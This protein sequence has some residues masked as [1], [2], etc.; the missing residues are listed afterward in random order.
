MNPRKNPVLLVPVIVVA[1]ALH[2][3]RLRTANGG[4]DV[5]TVS[6]VPWVGTRVGLSAPQRT[7]I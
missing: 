1:V 3:W 7:A 4:S 2:G 5:R 6:A